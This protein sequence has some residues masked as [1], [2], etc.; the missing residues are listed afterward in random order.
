MKIPVIF[1][2]GDFKYF[3]TLHFIGYI[4]N[5]MPNAPQMDQ[6][7]VVGTSY[8]CVVNCVPNCV[9]KSLKLCKIRGLTFH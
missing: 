1:Y 6:I 9:L 7:D 4:D 3:K 5:I 8:V 2:C